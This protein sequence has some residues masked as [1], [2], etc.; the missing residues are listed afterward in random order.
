MVEK[1]R[2]IESERE[3]RDIER[4]ERAR[5]TENDRE[6]EKRGRHM[7]IKSVIMA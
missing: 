5:G 4:G 7:L 6:R 2:E 3:E 1:Y